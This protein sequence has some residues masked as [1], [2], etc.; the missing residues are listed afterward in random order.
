MRTTTMLA[1]VA[2]TSMGAA[3]G[4]VPLIAGADMKPGYDFTQYASY[5]WDEPDSLITGDP[6]FDANPFFV[7]GMHAAIHWE[8]ATRGI[9]Y[10]AEGASL[11]VH[12]HALVRDRIEVVEADRTAGYTSQHGD[13]T[14]VIRYEEGTFLVD[15]AD[16]RTKEVVWRGWARLDLANALDDPFEMRKQIN[17]AIAEMFESLPIPYAGVTQPEQYEGR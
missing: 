10:A 13:D 8:F 2:A 11:T 1:L 16:A 3:C 4:G 7:H 14:Q 15:I 9:E 12:H 5:T 17:H 6:R